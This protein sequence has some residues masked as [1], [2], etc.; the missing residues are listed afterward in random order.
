MPCRKVG[1][2]EM[3]ENQTNWNYHTAKNE[4]NSTQLLMVRIVDLCIPPSIK[5]N[6]KKRRKKKK[7]S[8]A[9]NRKSVY[10]SNGKHLS[11]YNCAV[12]TGKSLCSVWTVD[13][14]IAVVGCV[15]VCVYGLTNKTIFHHILFSM[16]FVQAN[17]FKRFWWMNENVESKL[18]INDF[19]YIFFN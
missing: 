14:N 4:Q 9:W 11:R 10:I 15:C 1:F 17:D 13:I 12:D 8:F 6:S 19:L 5:W 16:C 7:S 3:G 2:N 18:C